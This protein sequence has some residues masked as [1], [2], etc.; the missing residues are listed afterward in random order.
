MPDPA[1]HRR[2]LDPWVLAHLERAGLPH[3]VGTTV[4]ALLAIG[5]GTSAAAQIY[6]TKKAGAINEQ[7]IAA[8]RESEAATRATELQKQSADIAAANLARTETLAA[9]D[10]ARAE[11]LAAERDSEQRRLDAAT[12]ARTGD[13]T[14]SERARQ[15]EYG[16]RTA[17]QDRAV[18]LDKARYDAYVAAN[19][20]NWDAGAKIFGSL[21]DLARVGSASSA[22]TAGQPGV[23][24]PATGAPGPSNGMSLMDL[25]RLTA[26]SGGSLPVD[27]TTGR[28]ITSQGQA[29]AAKPVARAPMTAPAAA[30]SLM[31]LIRQALAQ[32]ASRPQAPAM[33][34][35]AGG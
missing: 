15:E 13:Y 21:A 19:K 12:S 16:Y 8:Q 18:A 33:S 20:P 1:R 22:P 29:M 31:D 30:P 35:G 32:N 2:H 24:P 4:A 28:P 23:T 7:S 34:V 3:V 6:S 14:E 10:K 17:S 27:Q 26:S 25:A 5:A 11:T 9:T